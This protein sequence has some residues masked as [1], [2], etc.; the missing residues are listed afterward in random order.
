MF[1]ILN[2][3]PSIQGFESLETQNNSTEQL[4]AQLQEKVHE[5]MNEEDVQVCDRLLKQTFTD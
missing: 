1:L 5:V 4:N 2:T 3:I